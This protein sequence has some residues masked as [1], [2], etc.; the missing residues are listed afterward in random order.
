MDWK[1]EDISIDYRDYVNGLETEVRD[2][3]QWFIGNVQKT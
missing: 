3:T 2:V 1:R